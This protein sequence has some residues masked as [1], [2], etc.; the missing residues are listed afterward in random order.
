[1]GAPSFQ[2]KQDAEVSY[3]TFAEFWPKYL[4]EH[5]NPLN[6]KL[7][8]IGTSFA[9]VFLTL[10]VLQQQPTFFLA[11]VISGYFFAWIGHFFVQKNTPLTFKYPGKS[12]VADFKLYGRL[13]RLMIFKTPIA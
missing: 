12:L 11:A 9:L 10:A 2:S 1:M 5:S 3:K 8:F 4:E 7:H 6:Q 13:W